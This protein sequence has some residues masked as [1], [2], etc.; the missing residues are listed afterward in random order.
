M[1]GRPGSLKWK[2]LKSG[3]NSLNQAA[4]LLVREKRARAI[5]ANNF[6]KEFS[7]THRLTKSLGRPKIFQLETT[8]HCPYTCTMCPRTHSMTRDHGHMDIGLLRTVLDQVEPLC[9]VDSVLD[10]PYIALWHFG[11]PTVYKHFVEAVSYSHH[12]GLRVILSTNP[13]AWTKQRIHDFFDHGVDEL[14]VMFDGMDDDT[15]IA[16]RGRL[17]GFQRG[18]ANFA[19]LLAIKARLGTGRP[20]INVSMVKQQRNAHQWNLFA[21]HW[22][23]V[24]GVDN[25]ILG[26]FSTFGGDLPSLVTI[27]N[28]L[29]AQ[30]PAQSDAVARYKRLTKVPCYYPWHSVTVT[31]DGKVVP[32]CRDHNASTVLGDL[33]KDSL[34]SV[35]N[36]PPLQELRRQFLANHVTAAP[37]AT[38][39][40]RSAEIG[41]PGRFYPFSAVN[42]RRVLA[43][44]AGGTYP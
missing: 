36:G 7:Y 40:E 35:W 39:R 8:N 9:Q 30:D 25:V 38:C 15:S 23:N 34:E 37:C 32:C 13:S 24:E 5:Y 44:M 43:R 19:E 4:S 28:A 27:S 10:E 18:N 22:K 2:A 12:R 29:A 1:A 20:R 26:D 42:A 21:D 33:R 14:Y 11:E 31:W 16:I 17:A 41:L 3:V 6:L